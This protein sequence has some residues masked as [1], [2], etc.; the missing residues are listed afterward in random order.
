MGG[1]V[2]S[3]NVS[4]NKDTERITDYRRTF[5][6]IHTKIRSIDKLD[7]SASFDEFSKILFI[8]I[9]NDK[10]SED[11][12]LTIERI[13]TYGTAKSQSKYI[14]EWFQSKVKEH[15]PGIFSLLAKMPG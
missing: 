14:D 2:E 8:K 9:I 1:Y 7:P 13:K 6:Q 5:R 10:I 4:K 12:Q 11:E 15:Y 3:Q